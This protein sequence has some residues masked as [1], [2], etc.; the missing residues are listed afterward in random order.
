MS[1][2]GT[3]PVFFIYMK[4]VLTLNSPQFVFYLSVIQV[5]SLSLTIGSMLPEIHRLTSLYNSITQTYAQT[6]P[7]FQQSISFH[8]T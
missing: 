7:I 5:C 4:I 2:H 6:N 3:I 8:S 1:N